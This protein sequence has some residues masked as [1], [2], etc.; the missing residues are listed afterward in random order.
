MVDVDTLWRK[1][2]RAATLRIEVYPVWTPELRVFGLR[3]QIAP[4]IM[5]DTSAVIRSAFGGAP[6]QTRVQHGRKG[7]HEAS[8]PKRS[9]LNDILRPQ[10]GPEVREVLED[11]PAT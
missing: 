4:D 1:D 11:Q 5:V 3:A 10:S 6:W 7:P 9:G 8:P 2:A